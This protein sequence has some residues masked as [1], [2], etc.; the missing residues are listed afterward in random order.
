MR[1]T[2]N[3]VCSQDR[4]RHK[5]KAQGRHSLGFRDISTLGAI[6]RF[7]YGQSPQLAIRM[8]RSVMP[9]VQSPS[10]PHLGGHPWH[11]PHSANSLRDSNKT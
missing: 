1:R 5:H 9:I 3:S 8:S 2:T 4:R 7:S 11:G 6:R 10:K